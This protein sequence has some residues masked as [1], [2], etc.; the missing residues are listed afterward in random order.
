MTA[1][2]TSTSAQ[3]PPPGRDGDR[4]I[5]LG[6]RA[7]GDGC[8]AYIIAEAGVNHDGALDQALALVDA[9]AAGGADAVK[10]QWF[11][12]DALVCDA[13]PLA[14][15]Q[16]GRA[17]AVETGGGQRDMLRRLELAAD[18]FAAIAQH[19]RGRGIDFLATPFSIESLDAYAASRPPAVKIA[20]T[21][22]VNRPLL[23]RAAATG[24]PL[25]LSTGASTLD[26][27]ARTVR[28]LVEWRALD[29][30]VLMHCVSAYPT[31]LSEANIAAVRGLRQRFGVLTGYSDHTVSTRT[32]GWAVA[33]GACVIEKHLT[34][35]RAAD[36]PDHAMSLDPD[37]FR[38]YV[39]HA[40]EAEQALGNGAPGMSEVERDVR[41]VARRS[42]VAAV[43][44]PAGT[45]LTAE[46]LT[47]KRPGGGIEPADLEQLIGRRLTTP[48]TADA[49]LSWQVVEPLRGSGS[50]GVR[51]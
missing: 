45:V 40:R 31:P 30:A 20:S 50:E 19:C 4:R 8:P 13:A 29:R 39:S 26:E 28:W 48:L 6:R 37:G 33:C 7:I 21:D 46:M 24:L 14:E 47:V 25:L 51:E 16:R 44:L 3:P 22:L 11:T 18:A 15:Y 9:A 34:L 32:G 41:E 27:I 35:N 43:D 1:P 38:D 5:D 42:V 36:G 23:Q 49:P 10:F 12:A 2:P 17:P